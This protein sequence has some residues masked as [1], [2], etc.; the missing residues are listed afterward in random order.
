MNNQIKPPYSACLSLVEYYTSTITA[1]VSSDQIMQEQSLKCIDFSQLLWPTPLVRLCVTDIQDTE[2]LK[3][4]VEF[5][6]SLYRR[7][8]HLVCRIC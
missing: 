8:A 3:Q 6:L 2:I 1:I 4:G 7:K 5:N